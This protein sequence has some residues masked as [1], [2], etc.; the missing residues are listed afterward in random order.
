MDHS[1][2]I[3]ETCHLAAAADGEIIPITEVA[4]PV[5]SEKM[6]GEGY[7]ILPTSNEVVAPISGILYEVADTRHAFVIESS[8]G[9][10]VL[11]HIGLNTVNLEGEGFYTE[12]KTGMTVQKGDTLAQFERESLIDKGIDVTILV[13]VVKGINDE[14][15]CSFNYTAKATGG[16]TNAMTIEIASKMN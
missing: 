12:L 16:K 13:V 6:A 7:A 11:V 1:E 5:F 3:I 10:E 4:D 9:F 8:E 14:A 2:K 15:T